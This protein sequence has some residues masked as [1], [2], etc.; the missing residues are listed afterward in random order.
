[1]IGLL[2]TY[3]QAGSLSPILLILL[4][5]LQ[6]IALGGEYG[7]AAIY[8]AEHARRDN[9]RRGDRLDPVVRV[10]SA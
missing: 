7:G 2:P 3:A 6:G 4:R 5:I 1:M 10:A 8:V 9:A